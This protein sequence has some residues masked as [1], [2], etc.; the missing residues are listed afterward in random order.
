MQDEE[1]R[2]GLAHAH[3]DLQDLATLRPA[4]METRRLS[5][6]ICAGTT[7]ILTVALTFVAAQ[8]LLA[9][10]ANGLDMDDDTLANLTIASG[11][12]VVVWLIY[13]WRTV[14]ARGR[15]FRYA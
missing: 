13:L 5:W 6:R 3:D 9:R 15:L 4:T 14:R 8:V 12:G 2:L 11:V 1:S 10:L 7:I